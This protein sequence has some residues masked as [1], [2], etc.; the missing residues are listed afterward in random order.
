ME[1]SANITQIII[2]TINTLFENL[3]S[4]IDNNIYSLLDDIIFIGPNILK[5]SNF[6]KIFGTSASNGIL[7][8][9]NSFLL[10]FIIYYGSKYLLSHFTFSKIET[11]FSFIIKLIIF[12]IS[13]N[14]SYFIVEQI[15]SINYNITLAIQSIG[16]HLFNKEICFSELIN[17]INSNIYIDTNSI[18]I[19][20]IDGLIKSTLSVSL[21]S[22]V[23]SYSLRYIILKIFILLSPFAFLSLS[24]NSTN[25]FFKSW[26]KNFFSLLL[27]QIIVSFVLL[28]LFSID[29]NGANLL[30]KFIY[31]GA[32]YFLTRVNSF[33]RE[34]IGGVSTDIPQSVYNFLSYK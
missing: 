13:M 26:F 23:F 12:G 9:S 31:I 4:S 32:I 33:I 1:N 22:L 16:E 17:T 24:L 21:L 34:F 27:I 3:L 30:N 29:Y 18:N 10:A 19:F 5:D 8:I 6:E 15:L 25:C 14:F 2:N 20:S 7:L 28:L 11:P